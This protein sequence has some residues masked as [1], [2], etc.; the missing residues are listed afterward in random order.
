MEDLGSRLSR[1]ETI[2]RHAPVVEHRETLEA[3]GMN[4]EAMLVDERE[5][6]AKE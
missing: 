3:L 5:G 4:K 1:T 2:T 6:N